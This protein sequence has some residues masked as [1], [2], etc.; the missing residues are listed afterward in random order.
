MDTEWN[1]PG[2]RTSDYQEKSISNQ[3]ITTVTE[4]CEEYKCK[5]YKPPEA[6]VIFKD[7]LWVNWVTSALV[8]FVGITVM[9]RK[10][11]KRKQSVEDWPYCGVLY[12]IPL[13]K[14]TWIPEGLLTF[15]LFLKI[16]PSLVIDVID[17]LFD[18]IYYAQLVSSYE[19]EA[20]LN[21]HIH[22][23]FYVFAILFTFQI[24][25]TI[26]NIILVLY[27][28]WKLDR[29]GHTTEEENESALADTNAYMAITFLQT[30]LAFCMQDAPE[31]LT[32]YFFVDKYLEDFNLIVVV[33]SGLR[34]LMSCRTL[35][36]FCRHIVTFIDPA[37]HPPRVRC[38]LWSLVGVKFIIFLAH[39]LRS[40]AVTF[41]TS[42]SE[43]QLTCIGIHNQEL[44]Q[45]V[46]K[47]SCLDT[48]DRTLLVFCG[49]S[50]LGVVIGLFAYFKYGKKVFNQS[51]HSGRSGTV[52]MV[53]N[54]PFQLQ[55][56]PTKE[57]TTT[58]TDDSMEYPRKSVVK[59]VRNDAAEGN[60]S[61]EKL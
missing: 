5:L 58:L 32:Q 61:T 42:S 4:Y 20:I 25:G 17:I 54:L 12:G 23:Q 40:V 9:Y 22:M 18:N 55:S 15:G 51:H 14:L 26:K 29:V 53:R 49:L 6:A 19:E 10:W 2:Y 3:S 60:F 59:R 27:A 30:I 7:I 1:P 13:T 21:R 33:A 8:T 38:L 57:A 48:I 24:T 34:F 44:Y 36:I 35:Y 56:D 50:V 47:M 28:K 46:W 16:V 11:I 52:N 31:A 43:T 37:F 41:T 45:D 39:G